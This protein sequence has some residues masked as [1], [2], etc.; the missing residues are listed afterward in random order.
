[1]SPTNRRNGATIYLTPSEDAHLRQTFKSRAQ[2]CAELAGQP[3]QATDASEVELKRR[4]TGA[5]LM[6]DMATLTFASESEEKEAIVAYAVGNPYPP[7]ILPFKKLKPMSIRELRIGT[8]HR[9]R[10][11]NLRRVAPVARLRVNS[12]NGWRLGCMCWIYWIV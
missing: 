1:M 9:G 10:V 5:S 3:R 11:L 4:V 6:A 7:C 8:H 2:K 12:W